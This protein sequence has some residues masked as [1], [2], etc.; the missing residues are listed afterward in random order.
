MKYLP[1]A[2]EIPLERPTPPAFEAQQFWY[3]R[4]AAFHVVVLF[5]F[6][7]QTI[8]LLI[9]PFQSDNE[10]EHLKR[11]YLLS[12]GEIFSRTVEGITGGDIDTGLLEYMESFEDIRFN[13]DHKITRTVVRSTRDITWSGRREFRPFPNT[14]FYFPL[15]YIPQATAFAIGERCRMTVR[16]SYYLARTLSLLATLAL[17]YAAFVTFPMPLMVLAALSLPMSLFQIGSASL[18]SVTFGMAVL[19]GALFMRGANVSMSFP[20][21]MHGA[22]A[23]CIWWL[24]TS[25]TNLFALTPLLAILF[26]YRR[27]RSYFISASIVAVLS[28]AW[29]AYALATVKGVPPRQAST[30]EIIQYYLIGHGSFARVLFATVT[31]V[32]ILKSYWRMFVGVVGWI[33]LPLGSGVYV[34]F[35]ILLLA[36]AAICVGVRPRSTILKGTTPLLCSVIASVLL[37][38][39]LFLV[40]YNQHPTN[41]IDGIEG[42]Y[43]I[44]PLILT[45]YALFSRR[46]GSAELRIGL[47]LVSMMILLAIVGMV[48]RLLG[49]Y[50]MT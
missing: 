1:R 16:E 48:P 44:T 36:L 6:I 15:P 34:G 7:A 46:L 17:V 39:F 12:K 11:A 41:F 29:I 25:R 47:C 33:D 49:R 40:T 5:L 4:R 18:D 32:E 31:N 20:W 13:Y 21:Y 30:Q 38:F 19:T 50:W 42:R 28:I 3:S 2:S 23:V 26:L 43:F 9:P 10:S 37:L 27:S 22:I 14:S 24:A 45:A 35:A 8:A